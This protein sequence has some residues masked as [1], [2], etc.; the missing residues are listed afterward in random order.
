MSEN[1]SFTSNDL[2][3]K[4]VLISKNVKAM[5]ELVKTIDDKLNQPKSDK[6]NDKEKMDRMCENK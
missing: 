1:E 2:M 6:E 3:K 5:S 4:I